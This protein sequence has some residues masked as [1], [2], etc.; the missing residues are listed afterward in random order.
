[1][2]HTALSTVLALTLTLVA[3]PALGTPI[4]VR[5]LSATHS[6]TVG[7]SG[8]GFPWKSKTSTASS[9]VSESLFQMYCDTLERPWFECESVT[10]DVISP[11]FAE[12]SATAGLL[13]LT[14]SAQG[15]PSPAALA[16]ADSE[17]TFSPLV[18]GV[19]DINILLGNVWTSEYASASLFDVTANQLLWQFSVRPPNGVVVVPTLLSAQHVYAMDLH[20]SAVTTGSGRHSYVRVSG[21][22]A[23]AV[24]DNVDTFMC[25][26]MG[27]LVA[28][29][30]RSKLL[31]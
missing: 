18:D 3:T 20:A 12:A 15:N 2:R 6:V 4:D 11:A 22:Q 16:T 29:L 17:W 7:I 23:V 8:F 31:T 28:L 9:P 19:A 30:G 13:E 14:A 1:M 27:L 10:P 25:L 26:C 24:P 5:V 21:I